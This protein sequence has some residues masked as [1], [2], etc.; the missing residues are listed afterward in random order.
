MN[1]AGAQE[2]QPPIEPV[3]TRR[4][5]F[6]RRALA[7]PGIKP[8]PRFLII[9]LAL[10]G[11]A[12]A[13]AALAGPA[14]PAPTTQ[15]TEDGGP[16]V[17]T[18]NADRYL[19]DHQIELVLVDYLATNAWAAAAD[20]AAN[21]EP[22]NFT[23][24]LLAMPS[25]K[26][27]AEYRTNRLSG[28]PPS[29][30]SSHSDALYRCA[31]DERERSPTPPR[32]WDDMTE[33]EQEAHARARLRTFWTAVSPPHQI[34]ARAAFQ[35]AIDINRENNREFDAFAAEYDVCKQIGEDAAPTFVGVPNGA[36]LADIWLATN[37]A[38]RTCAGETTEALFPIDP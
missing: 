38:M 23:S 25:T 4:R 18:E 12:L 16:A 33:I 31:K 37:G 7:R 28:Y 24:A 32:S 10:T 29:R 36:P 11:A 17:F 26:C 20:R 1:T 19:S 9:V 13:L 3:S 14:A 15:V 2:L 22:E 35:S 21:E 27:A 6:L 30:A 8:G 5:R 34:M